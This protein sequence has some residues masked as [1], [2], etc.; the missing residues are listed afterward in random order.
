MPKLTHLDEHGRASMVDVSHKPETERTAMARGEIQMRR[1]TFDLIR[2]GQIKKGDVLTV[3]QI[4]GILAAKKTA[5]LIP[6]CHPLALSKIDIALELNEALP[7][8]T[9][10][11]TVK[12]TG[13]TGVEM[14]ALTAISIAALTVYDMAKAAEKTMKIQNIRLVEKHGGLSGDVVNE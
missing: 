13:Q 7:G 12:T 4:A 14:E 3:A 1:E 11:A 9:I 6:L 5:D 2:D 8:V 10:T